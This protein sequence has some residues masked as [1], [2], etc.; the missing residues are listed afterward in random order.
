MENEIIKKEEIIMETNENLSE[1]MKKANTKKGW[2]RFFAKQIDIGIAG[3]FAGIILV[4]MQINVSKMNISMIGL[5]SVIAL[6]P[7]EAIQISIMGTTIGKWLFNIK[8][9][10]HEDGKIS[11]VN[12]LKRSGLVSLRGLGMGIPIVTLITMNNGYK[13]IIKNGVL[14]WDEDCNIEVEYKRVNIIKIS[15][16]TLLIIGHYIINIIEF[17]N[18][19]R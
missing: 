5:I 10:N 19:H 7:I 4:L 17:S 11:L 13:S 3:L 2:Y 15:F 8:L 18:R 12:S 9:K 1:A 16:A 14:S 6:I